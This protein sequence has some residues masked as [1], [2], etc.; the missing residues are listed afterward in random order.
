MDDLL[1]DKLYEIE[2]NETFEAHLPRVQSS[3]GAIYFAKTGSP[4][5]VEQYT[6]ETSSLNAI[7]EVAPGIAPRIFVHGITEAGVPYFISEYKDISSLHSNVKAANDL[8]KRIATEMHAQANPD[9][10]GFPVPTYCGR[11]RLQNGMFRTWHQCYSSRIGDLL[12]QLHHKGRYVH[13]C[14]K[15]EIVKNE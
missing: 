4:S 2:P 10:F 7:N 1:L 6:G 12:R 13:L 5:E 9:G 14:R 8:A 11:T 3:S 15:G